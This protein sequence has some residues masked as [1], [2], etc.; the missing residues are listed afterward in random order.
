V[1]ASAGVAERAAD[2][3]PEALLARADALLYA[4]KGSGGDRL[5]AG[6]AS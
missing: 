6:A 3:P 4:A 1:T 5:R 2:E